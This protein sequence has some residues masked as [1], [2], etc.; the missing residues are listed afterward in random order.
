MDKFDLE[1][2]FE[3]YLKLNGWNKGEFLEKDIEITRHIFY[4]SIG[5]FMALM[6]SECL[7]LS[8]DDFC[9]V[10]TGFE[11]QILNALKPKRPK[12]E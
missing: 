10:M 6:K 9:K 8:E 4:G 11:D 1:K 2:Q 7:V 5:M 3:L 12:T